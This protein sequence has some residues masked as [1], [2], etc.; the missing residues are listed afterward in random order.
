MKFLSIDKIEV[1]RELA[2]SARSGVLAVTSNAARVF[3]DYNRELG[4]TVRVRSTKVGY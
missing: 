2:K 3:N 1:V 4:S